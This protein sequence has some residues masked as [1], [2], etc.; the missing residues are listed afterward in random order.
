M[1]LAES[2]VT[3]ENDVVK[4][5]RRKYDRGL[6]TVADTVGNTSQFVTSKYQ[7]VRETAVAHF[8]SLKETVKDSAVSQL[9]PLKA[10]LEPLK[11]NAVKELSSVV[12]SVKK[13]F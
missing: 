4:D 7:T 2:Q 5:L 9:E 13:L 3:P 6:N 12:D 10:Q 8:G 1:I 11:D